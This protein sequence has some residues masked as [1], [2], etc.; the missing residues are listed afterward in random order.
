MAVQIS[1]ELVGTGWASCTIRVDD[2]TATVT[3]SY[4]SDALDDL[5]S[6]VAAAFRGHPHATASFT[7]E[8]GE[9]RW[10]LEPLPEGK[11]S[12]RIIEFDEMWAGR[13]DKD[14]S[15]IFHAECRLR[16]FAGALLSEVQRLE[17]TYGLAGY[18]LKWVQ[19]DFPAARL[20]E[21]RQLLKDPRGPGPT[22]ATIRSPPPRYTPARFTPQQ[23][24]SSHAIR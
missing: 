2:A 12:V 4:L 15:V 17:S 23:E 20:A 10:I 19:Y 11:V 6:A 16:T 1:Y 22:G 9:Y 3:A 18:R 24:A 7:E 8:P 5:A 21:L 13:P 14:G